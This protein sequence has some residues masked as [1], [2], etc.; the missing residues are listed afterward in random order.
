MPAAVHPR[1]VLALDSW[2]DSQQSRQASS[3]QDSKQSNGDDRTAAMLH[4]GRKGGGSNNTNKSSNVHKAPNPHSSQAE[5]SQNPRLSYQYARSQRPQPDRKEAF[6]NSNRKRKAEEATAQRSSRRPRVSSAPPALKDEAYIR[7]TMHIPTPKDYPQAGPEIFKNPKAAIN[8]GTQGLATLDHQ[9][10]MIAQDVWQL[11]LAYKSPGRTESVIAEGR[12]K[13][14]PLIH[15]FNAT[16]LRS[17]E[18]RRTGRVL[19]PASKIPRAW[20]THGSDRQA[21]AIQPDESKN[22]TRDQK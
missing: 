15:Q 5:S 8:D 19:A 11:T 7:R 22:I 13:V 1:N 4:G 3:Y 21:F 16:C 2:R 12:S 14:S 18:I 10:K 6:R 20:G 17:T 9:Y